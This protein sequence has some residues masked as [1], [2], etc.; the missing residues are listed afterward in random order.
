MSQQALFW[1]DGKWQSLEV[2]NADNLDGKDS[3]DFSPVGH[4]HF[5]SEI[6]DLPGN[7][8]TTQDG[9]MAA[10]DKTKLNGIAVNANNYT[11]PNDANTRHVTDI[12]K[13][14]WNG[15]A[16]ASHTHTIAN[17]AGL[18]DQINQ[19]TQKINSIETVAKAIYVPSTKVG[20]T[21]LNAEHANANPYSSA[22]SKLVARWVATMDGQITVRSTIKQA[23]TPSEWQS[24]SGSV[25]VY[26]DYSP[27]SCPNGYPFN[28]GIGATGTPNFPSGHSVT[29]Q[30]GGSTQG[31]NYAAMTNTIKVEKGKTYNFCIASGGSYTTTGE[32]GETTY[33]PNTIW[34]NKIELLFETFIPS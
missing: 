19:L 21:I 3:L 34:C 12:E 20:A 11:H 32:Y 7:A 1:I 10:A 29:S 16:N 23:L 31:T 8:T 6:T 22:N 33:S 5:K 25:T 4:K 18:Q 24:C 9:F 2:E 15:K 17:I 27:P 14:T 28:S 26:G 30:G 13:S